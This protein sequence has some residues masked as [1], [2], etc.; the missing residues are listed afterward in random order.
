VLIGEEKMHRQGFCKRFCE[1]GLRQLDK[2][3]E[4][5]I[6]TIDAV[7]WGDR[8]ANSMSRMF[9]LGRITT[10]SLVGS[11]C[12]ILQLCTRSR[13]RIRQESSKGVRRKKKV[14]A[15]ASINEKGEEQQFIALENWYG[16][17]KV[18]ERRHRK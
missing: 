6:K 18:K 12:C 15:I 17:T 1:S 7:N 4:K 2:E 11:R 8:A 5:T 3:S 9:L 10:P 13:L 16:F 14:G